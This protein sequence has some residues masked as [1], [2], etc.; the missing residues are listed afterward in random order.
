MKS[1]YQGQTLVI[2]K[3]HSRVWRL[4]LPQKLEA[5]D[6]ILCIKKK[7]KKK[8]LPYAAYSTT[9]KQCGDPCGNG[10]I[11]VCQRTTFV[12]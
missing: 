10:S 3:R 7:K 9:L 8:N 5:L 6:S 11:Q 2:K 12:H 4:S 1:F